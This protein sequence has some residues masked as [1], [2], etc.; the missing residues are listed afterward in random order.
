MAQSL[1][2]V[3]ALMSR[4]LNDFITL[5]CIHGRLPWMYW[6]IKYDFYNLPQLYQHAVFLYI[7]ETEPV[8]SCQPSLVLIQWADSIQIACNPGLDYVELVLTLNVYAGSPY[9]RP[10]YSHRIPNDNCLGAYN[11]QT[12]S[13]IDQY[14][15]M[16]CLKRICYR[17]LFIYYSL[18]P[19]LY[20]SNPCQ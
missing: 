12:T 4:I 19:R 16:A 3:V 17:N 14:L 1:H 5:I 9:C 8:G 2:A 11:S 6:M 10:L 7:W 20:R 13:Y 18:V 15:I